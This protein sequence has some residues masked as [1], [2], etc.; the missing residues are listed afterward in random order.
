MASE[1][2][3]R[4]HN[5]IEI[6]TEVLQKFHLP[7]G[8][9]MHISE[10]DGCIRLYPTKLPREPQISME[11]LRASFDTLPSLVGLEEEL[12]EDREKW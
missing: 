6:P 11:E 10:V 12:Y 7:I 2:V 5:L 4:D 9:T 8:S 3:I 1:A